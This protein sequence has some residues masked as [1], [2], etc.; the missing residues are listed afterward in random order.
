MATVRAHIVL[1]A[2]LAHEIDKIAG[3]RGRSAFLVETAEKEVRRRKLLAFLDSPEPAWKE[4]DHPDI[5]ELGSAAWVH[6]LRHEKSERQQ[7]IEAWAEEN[8]RQ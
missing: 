8:D 6:N 4:E 1:P 2:E 7:R 3:P 5:A